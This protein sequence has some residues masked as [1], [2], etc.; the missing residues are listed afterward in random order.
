M[1][2]INHLLRFAEQELSSSLLKFLFLSLLIFGYIQQFPQQSAP[3][4]QTIVF[5]SKTLVKHIS[6]L[7]TALLHCLIKF[8]QHQLNLTSIM[9][10]IRCDSSWQ[11]EAEMPDNLQQNAGDYLAQF[12]NA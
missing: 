12:D 11:S 9:V 7:V 3:H 1:C 6:R 2:A 5:S 10:A 8:G 4:A